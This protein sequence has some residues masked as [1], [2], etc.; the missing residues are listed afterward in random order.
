MMGQP[1]MQTPAFGPMGMR[2]PAPAAGGNAGGMWMSYPYSVNPY[3]PNG[4]P[5]MNPFTPQQPMGSQP[6]GS[7]S[8]PQKQTAATTTKVVPPA[9]EQ[10]AAVATVEKPIPKHFTQAELMAALP[11]ANKPVRTTHAECA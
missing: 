4:M 6:V 9:P 2:F 3:A 5:M 8:V 10:P 7:S 11:S 1:M